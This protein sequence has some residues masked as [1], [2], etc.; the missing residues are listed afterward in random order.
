M[1]IKHSS[2]HYALSCLFTGKVYQ[3]QF[4][5][6]WIYLW[7]KHR[8]LYPFRFK[9]WTKEMKWI[10]WDKEE[11]N[12]LKSIKTLRLSFHTR[13]LN[14]SH[15]SCWISAGFCS[16]LTMSSLGPFCE[17]EKIQNALAQIWTLW[18]VWVYLNQGQLFW[19]YDQLVFLRVLKIVFC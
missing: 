4:W 16:Y 6:F 11:M 15:L 10:F 12:E 13:I 2:Y 8:I 14:I 19:S 17:E 7:C 18:N 5:C 1:F 9:M 3:N